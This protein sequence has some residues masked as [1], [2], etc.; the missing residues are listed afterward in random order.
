MNADL[1]LFVTGFVTGAFVAGIAFGGAYAG[2]VLRIGD[3]REQ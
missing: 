3:R 1:V 2:F